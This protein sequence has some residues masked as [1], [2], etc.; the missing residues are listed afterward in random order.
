MT[1]ELSV[2]YTTVWMMT[3]PSGAVDDDWVV[4]VTGVTTVE[5]DILDEGGGVGVGVGGVTP[6]VGVPPLQLLA[7]KVVV[8]HVVTIEVSVTGT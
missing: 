2:V 8:V 6:G 3:D 7:N 5:K 4:N 1:A